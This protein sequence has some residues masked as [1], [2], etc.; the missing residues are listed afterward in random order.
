MPFCLCRLCNEFVSFTHPFA[1]SSDEDEASGDEGLPDDDSD[2]SNSEDVHK[3]CATATF[4][5]FAELCIVVLRRTGRKRR[6]RRRWKTIRR[7]TRIPTEQNPKLTAKKTR[8][9]KTRVKKNKDGEML[10]TQNGPER[11]IYI[12][13]HFIFMLLILLSEQSMILQNQ[14]TLH[15]NSR[16]SPF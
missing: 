4:V 7:K 12:Y 16:S 13:F 6:W 8:S 10:I 14:G 9:T 5:F 15:Q 1:E 3:M 11:V 2:V